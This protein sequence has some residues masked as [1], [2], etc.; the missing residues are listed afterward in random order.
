MIPAPITPLVSSSLGATYPFP[1]N[2]W[3][4]TAVNSSIFPVFFSSNSF[5]TINSPLILHRPLFFQITKYRKFYGKF[6]KEIGIN[7]LLFHKVSFNTLNPLQ[8][9]SQKS[10]K[11]LKFF[12][13]KGFTF[14]FSGNKGRSSEWMAAKSL[15]KTEELIGPINQALIRR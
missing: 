2:T 11:N 3:R 9:N 8:T 7:L 14:F 5:Y 13:Q 1:P 4:G 15:A 10:R 12:Y 6:S